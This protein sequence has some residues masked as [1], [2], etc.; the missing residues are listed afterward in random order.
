MIRYLNPKILIAPLKITISEKFA[1]TIQIEM[2][3]FTPH[4]GQWWQAADQRKR[5][6]ADPK[7]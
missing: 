5:P 6:V 3:S 7:R 2:L 4:H 1:L